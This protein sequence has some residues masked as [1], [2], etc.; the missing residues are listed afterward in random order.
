[1]LCTVGLL[2]DDS[3]QLYWILDSSSYHPQLLV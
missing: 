3:I 2:S 1:M